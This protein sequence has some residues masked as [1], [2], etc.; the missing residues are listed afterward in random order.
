MS[1]IDTPWNGSGGRRPVLALVTG[2]TTSLESGETWTLGGERLAIMTTAAAVAA[3]PLLEPRGPANLGPADVFIALALF[4]AL[5]WL[6]SSSLRLRAPYALATAILIAAGLAGALAGPVP[7][8]GLRAV[9]QDAW[10]L[11]LGIC[12]VNVCR[13]P[14]ALRLILRTWVYASIAW[15]ALL[16]VGEAA[17]ISVLIGLQANEGGRTSLTFGDPNIAAHYFF[18]SIMLVAATRFP[19]RLLWRFGAY[20]LLLAAWALSGSNSGIVEILLAVALLSLLAIHRRSGTVPTIAVACC[21][22]AAAAVLV[23]RVPVSQLQ[24]SARDSRHRVIRDWVGRSEKTAGQRETLLGESVDL[25]YDG[26]LVG[27]GPASTKARLEASQAPFAREAHNDY[28]A[29]LVERGLVGALG[30][31]LLVGSVS[32][33]TWAVVTRPLS[34]AFAAVVPRAG[35]LLAAV[36]G[37]FVLGTVYEALHVRQVWALFAVVAALYYWGR[38]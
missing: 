12:V 25:Y 21:M 18:V 4:S 1:A 28:V 13:T 3:L 29:A 17:G 23:P 6:G 2:D 11:A 5:F 34:P 10:V 20:V 9:V 36:A 16:L 30:I 32:V 15:A 8:Q 31:M 26:G 24:D 38:R 33:R 22:V 14:H 37:T 7:L 19:A 35:P 27:Q